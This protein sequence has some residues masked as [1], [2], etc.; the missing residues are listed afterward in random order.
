MKLK[1]EDTVF[2]GEDKLKVEPLNPTERRKGSFLGGKEG[3]G[4]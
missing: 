2:G 4:N 1:E 3:P